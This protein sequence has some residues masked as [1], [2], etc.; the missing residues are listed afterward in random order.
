MECP[1]PVRCCG[2][3]MPMKTKEHP[4][5]WIIATANGHWS[6]GVCKLCR[7]TKAFENS[8]V[9]P[10]YRSNKILFDQSRSPDSIEDIP[11]SGGG[12]QW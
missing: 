4:H 6:K 12:G 2:I 1:I 11:V 8:V 9:N 5:Y 3:P 10:V 7:A